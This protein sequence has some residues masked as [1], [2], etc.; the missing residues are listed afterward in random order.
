MVGLYGVNMPATLGY[1]LALIL[2]VASEILQLYKV[3]HYIIH[4]LTIQFVLNRVLVANL[5]VARASSEFSP[6][7]ASSP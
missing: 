7:Q 5:R 2:L 1:F 4:S 6:S 3:R